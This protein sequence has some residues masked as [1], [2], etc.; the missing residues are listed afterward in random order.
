M[1][2]MK[3]SN[4]LILILVC[5]I[6]IFSVS[7]CIKKIDEKTVKFNSKPEGAILYIDNE[8]IGVTPIELKL[9]YGKYFLKLI[10]DGF[11]E[12]NSVIEI[13]EKTNEIDIEL[14]EISQEKETEES[15][16]NKHS[17]VG[18][19][20]FD[21]YTLYEV[22][23]S[24]AFYAYSKIYLNDELTISGYALENI[25]GFDVVFPSGK[26]VH[27]ETTESQYPDERY[28]AQEVSFDEIG[29]YKVISD[30]GDLVS[31]FD[32]CYKLELIS[33]YDET[34]EL[35]EGYDKEDFIMVPSNKEIALTFKVS[36]AKGSLIKNKDLGVYNLK[37]DSS[38]LV[39][40]KVLVKKDRSLEPFEV[41]INGI[42]GGARIY[43]GKFLIAYDYIVYSKDGKLIE[44]NSL[45]PPTYE[46]IKIIEENDSIYLSLDFLNIGFIDLIS[47]NFISR[48]N[49]IFVSEKGEE[50]IYLEGAV[51]LDGGKTWRKYNIVDWFDTIG[52]DKNSPNIIY[53]WT[54]NY[55]NF[56]L[57]SE[58]YGDSFKK[59]EIPEVDYVEKIFI[60]NEN[61]YLATWK[62]LL[63]YEDNGKNWEFL[64][65]DENIKT[66]TLN[67]KNEKEILIGTYDK[68]LK[69]NDGGKTW[70]KIDFKVYSPVSIVYDFN[71]PNII[72]LGSENGLYISKNSGES[73]EL[74]ES[75]KITG[76]E[77]I[78]V[79]PKN[80]KTIYVASNNDGIY[81]IENYGEKISK[82]DF[83][84]IENL[85]N[86]AIDDKNELFINYSGL[87]FKI[88]SNGK[89]EMLN[90]RIFLNKNTKIKIF[91]DLLF[92]DIKSVNLWTIKF[93]IEKD[94]IKIFYLIDLNPT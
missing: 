38:G 31:T 11:S 28:F 75:F 84:L 34:I 49:N 90:E 12:Y 91:D 10:K 39:K 59:I 69:S 71:N 46:N 37:S 3:K 62:G 81:K 65:K 15:L 29:R 6:V 26:K 27:F 61:I 32:V 76:K 17:I 7:S 94:K 9:K 23:C 8:E 80:S 83:P 74:L 40:F 41:F 70:K 30:N 77:G 54:N 36:D 87:P 21:K 66:F 2:Y 45:L 35:F 13:N 18:P 78:V 72:Y 22:C 92:V 60:F 14:V 47:S 52:V 50:I 86:I 42:K 68:I 25:E 82:V 5:L 67:P 58:D 88:N 51:S 89:I 53:A 1:I 63:K 19:I 73:F 24:A 16:R 33:G 4:L 79:D 20:I 44:T 43:D 93:I 57:K 48:E 56:L 64:Y 55:K 85:S